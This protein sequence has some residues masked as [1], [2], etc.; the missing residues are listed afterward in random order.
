VSIYWHSEVVRGV[1]DLSPMNLLPHR[2][3]ASPKL[4]HMHRRYR[5]HCPGDAGWIQDNAPRSI[6]GLSLEQQNA[7]TEKLE[8]ASPAVRRILQYR[9]DVDGRV[10]RSW[11]HVAEL[12]CMSEEGLRQLLRRSL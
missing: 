10:V 5:V 9:F 7:M 11:R 8:T 4:K 12:M 3:L 1:T 2:Y 6:P